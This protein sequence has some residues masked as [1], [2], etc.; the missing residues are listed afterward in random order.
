MGGA[1]AQGWLDAGLPA[2]SLTIIEPNPSAGIASLA[3]SRGGA[4]NP[5]IDVPPE[6]LPCPGSRGVAFNPRIDV[7]PEMLVLAVKPQSLDQ[8][9]PQ[10]AA[11]AAE[12][13]L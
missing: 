9:A 13:T 2:P 8:V 1:M 7:P 10:I 6:M 4:L 11:L 12:Q 3:A 5:R